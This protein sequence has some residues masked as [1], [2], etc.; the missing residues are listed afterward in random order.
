LSTLLCN[1]C[2]ADLERTHFDQVIPIRNAECVD[3]VATSPTISSS[4][5]SIG[6]LMRMVDD[7]FYV[8]T[9]HEAARYFLETMEKGF[10]DYGAFINQKKTFANF[11]RDPS[12]RG[13][14]KIP[15]DQLTLMTYIQIRGKLGH[16]KVVW[17]FVQFAHSRSPTKLWA[18]R[19]FM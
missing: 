4:S 1:L 10:P 18:I 14:R 12:S 13:E 5:K 6:L 17:V 7:F 8:T 9:S 16:S 2:Y 19:S 15:I 11:Q 3:S